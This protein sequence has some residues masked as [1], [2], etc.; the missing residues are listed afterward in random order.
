LVESRAFFFDITI[1][2]WLWKSI[3]NYV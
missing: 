3:D 1:G 2:I